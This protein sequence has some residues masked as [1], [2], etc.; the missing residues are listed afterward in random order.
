MKA[1]SIENQP[2]LHPNGPGATFGDSRVSQEAPRDDLETLRELL[3]VSR[4]APEASRDAPR[5]LRGRSGTLQK[6]AG[7]ASGAL[8]RTICVRNRFPVD[9]PSI[10]QPKIDLFWRCRSFGF[11]VKSQSIFHVFWVALSLGSGTAHRT[12]DYCRTLI[13]VRMA[14][15]S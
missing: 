7:D 11:T 5:T 14:S 2:K 8:W 1:K 4:D 13:F 15:V 6:H 3:G 9:L 12:A 10:F